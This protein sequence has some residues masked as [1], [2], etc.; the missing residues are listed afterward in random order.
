MN[1]KTIFM[2]LFFLFILQDNNWG[3]GEQ[4]STMHIIYQ[5]IFY[6]ITMNKYEN[7]SS[8]LISISNTKSIQYNIFIKFN[9]SVCSH[10]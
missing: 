5:F 6:I 1:T 7:I 10:I 8:K 2:L 3:G 9:Y 4:S